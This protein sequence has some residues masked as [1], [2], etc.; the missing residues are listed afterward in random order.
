MGK[1]TNIKWEER[2]EK[3]GVIVQE[4]TQIP[5]EIQEYYIAHGYDLRGIPLNA[6]TCKEIAELL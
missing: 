4:G 6:D 2:I 5:I 1:Y 3:D